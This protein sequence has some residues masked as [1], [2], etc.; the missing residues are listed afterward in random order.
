M[1]RSRNAF[2]SVITLSRRS[3]ALQLL[4]AV[5][6]DTVSRVKPVLPGKIIQLFVSSKKRIDRVNLDALHD[7]M[8]LCHVPLA[9]L[10]DTVEHLFER[11]PIDHWAFL[12]W[13]HLIRLCT[14]GFDPL[15][16]VTSDCYRATQL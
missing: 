16:P 14:S 2:I 11:F 3:L 8:K 1:A 4:R 12:N 5:P 7:V 13:S 6:R 10:G 9:L 15:P